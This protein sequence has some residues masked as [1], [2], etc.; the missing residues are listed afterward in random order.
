MVPGYF[1]GPMRR[2]ILAACCPLLLAAPLSSSCG[3]QSPALPNIVYI[4]T[5]DQGF[6]DVS[7]LNPEGRIPTPHM[8]RIAREGMTFTD[9]HSGSSVCTPTRYGILTGRYAWRSRLKSGVLGG[10][11]PRLIEADRM[12]VA[13]LL[14]EHGYHTACVGKWHLGM[15]WLVKEGKAVRELGFSPKID[16]EEGLK[17][18]VS[19]YKENEWI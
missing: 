2:A 19:W 7:R 3:G 15:D 10:L 16:P 1:E 6:G 8:D 4:L 14:K 9:A 12:T 17:Q 5:D 11:S 18:T 13:S